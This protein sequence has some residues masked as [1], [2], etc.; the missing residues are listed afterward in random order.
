MDPMTIGLL[1]LGL[2]GGIGGIWLLAGKNLGLL[3]TLGIGGGGGGILTMIVGVY[4]KSWAIIMGSFYG[5]LGLI[6]YAFLF[7]LGACLVV[8]IWNA[9]KD[10]KHGR[11]IG[12]VD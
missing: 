12:F 7:T 10:F 6:G 2:V 1:I 5:H 11:P 9:Y 4:T 3:K 8:W